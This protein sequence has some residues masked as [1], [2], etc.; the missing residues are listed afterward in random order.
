MGDLWTVVHEEEVTTT[1]T[2]R[3]QVGGQGPETSGRGGQVARV[4]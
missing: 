2:I 1:D 4:P 3:R